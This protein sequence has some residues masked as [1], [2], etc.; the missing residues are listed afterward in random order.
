MNRN[1]VALTLRRLLSLVE[2]GVAYLPSHDPESPAR[3]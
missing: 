3:L 1:R 2:S